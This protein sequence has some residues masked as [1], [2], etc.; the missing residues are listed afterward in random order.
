VPEQIV[1]YSDSAVNV[2][3]SVSWPARADVI[4][5]QVSCVDYDTAVSCI[6]RA[7]NNDQS[8]VVSCHAVH[9]IVT[10]SGDRSLRDKVNR[11]SMITPDGQ[12]VRWALNLLHGAGLRERVY[13]P[14]LTLRVCRAAAE[15]SVPIYLYGGSPKTL[16]ALKRQLCSQFPDLR[17]AGSESPPYR[18]LTDDE[19]AE[20]CERIN[21]SGAKILLI[22]LGCPKQD[23]F[24]AENSDRIKA[25]QLCVGAAFDFHAGAKPTA[26][27]WM[28]KNGLEWLF[29]LWCEPQRLWKRYLVTNTIFCV[30]LAISAPTAVW[31]RVFRV[32]EHSQPQ[33]S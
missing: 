31:R 27:G 19:N 30:K 23:L 3:S 1:D 18:A 26:P 13:G 32:A 21:R 22:G 20:A 33:A 11:F 28:Q 15:Q 17:I 29:R 8:G 12:P 25:V 24:A 16:E 10:A 7:A 14:E 9:A 4:G 6:L 2:E 5:V